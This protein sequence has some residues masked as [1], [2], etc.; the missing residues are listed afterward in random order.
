MPAA[1]AAD[2]LRVQEKLLRRRFHELFSR[3]IV[4]MRNGGAAGQVLFLVE[5]K[6]AHAQGAEG[7]LEEESKAGEEQNQG[8]ADV[9][10]KFSSDPTF[11]GA[12]LLPPF[13]QTN[14]RSQSGCAQCSQTSGQ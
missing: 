1:A 10:P 14:T 3:N 11:Y 2:E 13:P 7:A 6:Q 8:D 12:H 9:S 5:E 4:S